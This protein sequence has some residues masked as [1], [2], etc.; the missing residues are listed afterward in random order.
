M[1]DKIQPREVFRLSAYGFI[2]GF[3]ATLTVHQFALWL[4]RLATIA[5]FTAYNMAATQ[6]W[7]V[8]AVISLAFW[9][10]IWGVIFAF[11]QRAFPR[12]RRYWTTAF[13]F[14]AVLPSLVA[15]FIVLPIKG[16]PM[17][18]GWH[19]QLLLTAFLINGVWGLG[20]GALLRWLIEKPQ[21]VPGDQPECTTGMIC[22]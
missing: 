3:L 17:G 4:L 21:R 13:Y 18:G 11:A 1:T 15:L 16:R 20:T 10:G 7:G 12:S 22:S 8:P 6:P 2:A 19:W 9:G 14:G 5:P